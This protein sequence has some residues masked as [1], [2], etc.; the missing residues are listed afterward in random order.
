MATA[1]RAC[2]LAAHTPATSPSLGGR[3]LFEDDDLAAAFSRRDAAFLPPT[4]CREV[5]DWLASFS[6]TSNPMPHT[7][8][9]CIEA[10]GEAGAPPRRVY[11]KINESKEAPEGEVLLP[12]WLLDVLRCEPG[13]RVA[14]SASICARPAAPQRVGLGGPT[15]PALPT[16][17]PHTRVLLRAL[18]HTHPQPPPQRPW[19]RPTC[20]T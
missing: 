11:C 7:A 14:L 9:A 3:V 20:P 1:F 15:T 6:P 19:R 5:F 8:M 2:A 16:P 17:P 10:P 12:P 4:I 13:T 18:H